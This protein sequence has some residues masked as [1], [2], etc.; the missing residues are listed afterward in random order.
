MSQE[1]VRAITAKER[2]LAKTYA[3]FGRG[4]ATNASEHGRR[5]KR[6]E[7]RKESKR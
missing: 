2:D 6:N 5:K 4:P 3:Y 1:L 7:L